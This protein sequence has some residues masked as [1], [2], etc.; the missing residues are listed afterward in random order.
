MRRTYHREDPLPPDEG[1]PYNM[2]RV[3]SR[4]PHCGK[5]LMMKKGPWQKLYLS[6]AGKL[7]YFSVTQL[8]WYTI[9]ATEDISPEDLEYL[10]PGQLR[11]YRRWKADPLKLKAR[12][13][14]RNREIWKNRQKGIYKKTSRT[15][16]KYGKNRLQP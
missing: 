1:R 3:P 12:E 6:D 14:A 10:T 8:L 9:D 2:H 13:K 11:R 4:C 5:K 7:T 15:T 16:Q